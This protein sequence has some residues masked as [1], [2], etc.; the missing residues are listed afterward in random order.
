MK[1]RSGLTFNFL[2]IYA[3][4]KKGSDHML[5]LTYATKEIHTT[6]SRSLIHCYIF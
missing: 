1:V 3:L 6:K 4:Q 2:Y 5:N